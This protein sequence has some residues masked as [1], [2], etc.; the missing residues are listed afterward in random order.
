MWVLVKGEK[1][2]VVIFGDYQR[3]KNNKYLESEKNK[4][5]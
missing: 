5:I 3:A 1:S 2:L 4:Y